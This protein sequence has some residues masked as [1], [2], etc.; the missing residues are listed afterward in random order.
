MP[1]PVAGLEAM[2]VI[3]RA[4]LN[5]LPGLEASPEAA[6]QWRSDVDQIVITRIQK[7]SHRR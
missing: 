6:E 4:L 3:A 5:S 7:P 2:Q 1:P